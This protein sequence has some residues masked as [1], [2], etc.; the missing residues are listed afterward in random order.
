MVNDFFSN[1]LRVK[2]VF[3]PTGDQS[4]AIDG[5]SRYVCGDGGDG[6]FVLRG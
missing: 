3:E 2:M 4:A 6:I 1:A 5:L